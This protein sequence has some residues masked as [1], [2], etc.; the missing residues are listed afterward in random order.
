MLDGTLEKKGKSGSNKKFL[1]GQP[2]WRIPN[3]Q[4]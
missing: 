1:N 2:V 3:F 4:T